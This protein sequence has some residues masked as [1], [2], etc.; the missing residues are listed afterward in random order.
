M[1]FKLSVRYRAEGHIEDAFDWY[2]YK[3]PKVAEKFLTQL[4][5]SFTRITKTPLAFAVR[6]KNVHL[7]Q[8]KGFPVCVHYVV[9]ERMKKIT[10][11]A[12]LSAKQD[13]KKWSSL[14]TE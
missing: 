2:F 1:K 7:L 13:P 3:S 4:D 5:D 8:L 10:V 6:Y 12:V 11:I 14:L 9:N